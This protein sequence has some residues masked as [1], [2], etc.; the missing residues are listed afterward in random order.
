MRVAARSIPPT[1]EERGFPGGFP[2][3]QC[4][5]HVSAEPATGDAPTEPD[6]RALALAKGV[7][8]DLLEARQIVEVAIAR[9]A[10]ERRTEAELREIEAVLEAHR[11]ALTNPRPPIQQ[12]SQFHVLL[13]EAAH[14]EV[15]AGV[16]HS[17]RKLMLDRGPRLYGELGG[18]REWELDQHLHPSRA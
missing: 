10:A 4:I 16:F 7:T 1:P 11:A 18:F 5:A 8:H 9:L 12:A 13:A 14:N 3:E 2:L 6:V 17:F 15:L